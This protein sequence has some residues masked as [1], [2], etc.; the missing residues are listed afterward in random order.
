MS[1]YYNL[2]GIITEL[3]K[4][5]DVDK[6]LLKKW[7]EVT[8]P[9]KK[10][11]SP[12]QAMGKNVSGASFRKESYALQSGENELC[13]STWTNTSGYKTDEIKM[14]ELVRY[15]KDEKKK[16]KTENYMPKQTYL[17]QVYRYDADDMIDA[18]NRRIEYLEKQIAAHEQ[19][20]IK[21]E[22]AYNTFRKAFNEALQELSD[23]CGGQ[24]NS[25]NSTLYYM[26]KDTVI[27]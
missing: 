12:F 20:I 8:F 17:E 16:A 2:D 6:C 13:I 21:A 22:N 23:N 18:V 24:E 15:M 25:N 3:K 26:I 7:K 14:Y 11:G 4:T 9:R 5:I 27:R 1:N 10:D 19:Q